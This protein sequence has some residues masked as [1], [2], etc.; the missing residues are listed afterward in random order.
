MR[1]R[2]ERSLV[3]SILTAHCPR[4]RRGK[5]FLHP[6]YSK[7][8]MEMPHECPV[9][10]LPYLPE[11]GFY[12]GAA[13]ISYGINAILLVAVGLTLYYSPIG[14]DYVWAIVATIVIVIGLLPVTLR[15][16]KSFWIHL[17]VRYR[18]RGSIDRRTYI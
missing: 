14:V 7:R 9:C 18:G 6:M 13:Y 1:E 5:L 4:C 10:E 8:F 17:L 15:F 11:P 3:N 12:L 16:A 2:G